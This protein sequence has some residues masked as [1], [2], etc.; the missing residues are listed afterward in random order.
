MKKLSKYQS[1]VNNVPCEVSAANKAVA[2]ARLR[3]WLPG[4]RFTKKN[5]Y[6]VK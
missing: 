4:H 3:L 1:I 2:I 5:V 6:K